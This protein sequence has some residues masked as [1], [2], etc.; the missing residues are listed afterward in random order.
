MRKLQDTL[1][2]MTLLGGPK[3]HLVAGEA[4]GHSSPSDAL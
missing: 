3:F 1:I 4:K 2:I